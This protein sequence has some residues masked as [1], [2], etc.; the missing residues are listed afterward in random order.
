MK[1]SVFSTATPSMGATVKAETSEV[2]CLER[3][4]RAVATCFQKMRIRRL[5]GL[6]PLPAQDVATRVWFSLG[7][8]RRLGH[9]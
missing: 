3:G 6:P 2:T 7:E 5:P 1:E 8:G 4:G 9:I